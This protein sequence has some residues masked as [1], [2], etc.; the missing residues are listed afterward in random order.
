MNAANVVP[1]YQSKTGGFRVVYLDGTLCIATLY[2][3]TED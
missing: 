3:D 2:R 1:R